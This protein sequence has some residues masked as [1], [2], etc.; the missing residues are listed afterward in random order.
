MTIAFPCESCGHRYEVDGS[1]AGKK[2]RCKK[3]NHVFVIPV[4]QAAS[5]AS[6]R[7]MKSFGE[8]TSPAASTPKAKA[9]KVK[10]A[11]PTADPY[12][13]ADDPYG[14]DDEPAPRRKA[15]APEEDEEFVPR[16]TFKP[17]SGKPRKK[18]K[19]GVGSLLGSVPDWAYLACGVVVVAML[20]GAVFNQAVAA[21]V[22]VLALLAALACLLVGSIGFIVVPFRESVVCG[23]MALFVPF[24]G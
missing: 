22:M 3:C 20:I 14:F 4:P 21:A 15:P 10:P 12:Y 6:P 7:S 5:S 18:K 24:Y 1:L 19:K 23:L 16:Q 8:G 2:C 17:A 9:A 11:A 13:T